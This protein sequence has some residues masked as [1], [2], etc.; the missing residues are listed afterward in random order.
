MFADKCISVT[1][2]KKNASRHI[3]NLKTE[4]TKIIFVN[5]KPV[6]ALVDINNFDIHIDEPF[7]FTFKDWLD[8]KTILDHFDETK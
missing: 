8:P 3:K 7:S 1:E 2:L 6:A 5:N 4:W